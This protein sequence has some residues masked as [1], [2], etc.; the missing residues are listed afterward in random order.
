MN[1]EQ[2][3]GLIPARFGSTRFPGKP[4]ADIGGKT[5]I[6]RVY[7]QA[8]KILPFTFVATDDDRIAR[9]VEAFG[10]RVVMTSPHHQSGTDRCAEALKVASELLGK[11]FEVVVNIQGDEPFIDPAQIELLCTCFES[12]ETDIATLIK[13]ITNN[14]IVFDPNKPKVVIGDKHQA[15]YFSRSPIPYLRGVAPEEWHRHHTFYQHIG[16]YAYRTEALNRITQLPQSP[17]ELAE[18]LE[19]LRWL[20]NGL[21]ISVRETHHESFGIDSPADLEKIL[22]E[23]ML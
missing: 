11:S 21:T 15:L 2:F 23:G 12:P 7:E 4:L 14:S 16:L 13:P 22:K 10:G 20:E 5:M 18:S 8:T 3:I 9:E 1:N 6:Q 17:L 19:Q